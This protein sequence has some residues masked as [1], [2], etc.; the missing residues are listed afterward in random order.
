MDQRPLRNTK[1]IQNA[2]ESAIYKLLV[3][4][5]VISIIGVFLR[6]AGDSM[7]LSIVSWAILF[8]GAFVCCKAVFKILGA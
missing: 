3:V 4:G 2:N 1:S 6:F 5:V 8:A 7:T